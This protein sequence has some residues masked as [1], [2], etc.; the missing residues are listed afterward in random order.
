M[1]LQ[2]SSS[3]GRQRYLIAV[4]QQQR[5]AA[6]P[7]NSPATAKTG[8]TPGQHYVGNAN[9]HT[10]SA[11]AHNQQIYEV[12]VKGFNDAL[13]EKGVTRDDKIH[14]SL[15]VINELLRCSNVE[16]EMI[17]QELEDIIQQQATH[18]AHGHRY[19][20]LKELGTGSLTRSFR[21]LHQLHHNSQAGAQKGIGLSAVVRYHK[22]LGTYP[23]DLMPSRRIQVYESNTCKQ[24]MSEHF[25]AVC[26]QVLRYRS[27]KNVYIQQTLLNIIP[28][29]AAFQ[30]E[31]FVRSYLN[32]TMSYLL[33]CLKRDRERYN[34]FNAVGLLAVAV[35][36]DIKLYIPKIMDV[37]RA[38]LP[39]KDATIRIFRK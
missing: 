18:E 21:A 36:L 15:L 5:Q 3:K 30:T 14:G 11:E 37:I 13:K 28:R 24:L 34:A 26:Q 6:T 9:P 2:S 39:S 32:E 25:D 23:G 12:G 22:A 33:G 38:S 35:K 17:R 19:S 29:L 20:F 31:R 1:Q 10:Y 7:G 8:K 27:I 4:Q 16:G